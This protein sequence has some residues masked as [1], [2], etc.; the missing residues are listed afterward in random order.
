MIAASCISTS[1]ECFCGF[2]RVCI[3]VYPACWLVFF[4]EKF[5]DEQGIHLC[6]YSGF[7]RREAQVRLRA[8]PA[9]RPVYIMY[10]S[11]VFVSAACA[12]Q[13]LLVRVSLQCFTPVSIAGYASRQPWP[14]TCQCFISR[15]A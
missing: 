10:S 6:I 8:Q 13:R 9:L 2:V 3:R 11:S 15:A 4:F 1:F 5:V 7:I 14:G 12:R